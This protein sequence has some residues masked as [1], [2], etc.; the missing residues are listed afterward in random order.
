MTAT[1]TGFG[2]RAT[3]ASASCFGRPGE[4][5]SIFGLDF[6]YNGAEKIRAAIDHICALENFSDEAKE[7]LLGGNLRRVLGLS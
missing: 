5:A 3:S 7:K 2:T 1:R 6:P 4:D